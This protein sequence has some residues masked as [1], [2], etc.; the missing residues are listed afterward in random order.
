MDSLDIP[1][2][3]TYNHWLIWNIPKTE[4]IAENI[5]YGS[6]VSSLDNAIQ[7]SG[8]GAHRYRG[9]KQPVFIRNTHRYLFH[10]YALDCFLNLDVLQKRRICLK[11]CKDIFFKKDMDN[12]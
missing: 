11:L 12:R 8:Y 9:P 3:K 1:L 10:F 6:V 2:I 4:R 5:P 7:G